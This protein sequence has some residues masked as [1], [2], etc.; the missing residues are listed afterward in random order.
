MWSS[1]IHAQRRARSANGSPDLTLQPARPWFTMQ[2]DTHLTFQ[3]IHG[4][5][6][7]LLAAMISTEEAALSEALKIIKRASFHHFGPSIWFQS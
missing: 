4:D 6:D 3:Q 7:V 2:I 1:I 5:A